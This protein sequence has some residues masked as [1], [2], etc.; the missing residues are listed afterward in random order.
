MGVWEYEGTYDKFSTLGAKKYVYEK[1]GKISSTIAG[2]AKKAG[3]AFFKK[4]GFDGF[5]IG[6]VIRESG[7]LTAFYN[8]VD[9]YTIKAPDGYEFTSGSNVALVDNTYTIGVTNEYLD[10]LYKAKHDILNVVY[11]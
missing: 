1:D 10:L 4:Y 6:N 9:I 3:K 2:V 11:Q 5:K 7:H 8:D